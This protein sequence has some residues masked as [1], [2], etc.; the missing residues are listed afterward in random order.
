MAITSRC[1]GNCDLPH[2]WTSNNLSPEFKFTCPIIFIS[3]PDVTPDSTYPTN[4]ILLF[5]HNY[6]RVMK[7]Y[8]FSFMHTWV[9][10]LRRWR[11]RRHLHRYP[12]AASIPSNHS[13]RCGHRQSARIT[14][15]TYVPPQDRFSGYR[16]Q[17]VTDL[18]HRHSATIRTSIRS[19]D[20]AFVS[21]EHTRRVPLFRS[22]HSSRPLFSIRTDARIRTMVFASPIWNA[23]NNA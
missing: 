23:K 7:Y 1:V 5:I 8:V 19:S 20:V 16:L 21:F 10:F 3:L 22:I 6:P 2:V 11:Y 13:S 18:L 4:L 15:H 12:T 14:V 17:P 9:L